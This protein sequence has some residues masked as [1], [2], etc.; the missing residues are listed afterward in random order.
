MQPGIFRVGAFSANK[1]QIFNS[2]ERQIYINTLRC[3]ALNTNNFSKY[4]NPTI[5]FNDKDNHQKLNHFYLQ[6]KLNYLFVH[7]K[8]QYDV[9]FLIYGVRQTKTFVILGNFLPFYLLPDN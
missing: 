2:S 7:Q 6:K 9:R 8:S 1:A 3:A 5:K 4:T